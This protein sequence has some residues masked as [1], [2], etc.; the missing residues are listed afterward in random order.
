MLGKLEK[1]ENH[2]PI[3]SF[4]AFS[5][6]LSTSGVFISENRDM[7]NVFYCLNITELAFAFRMAILP[8][9]T[10]LPFVGGTA[11]N[12]LRLSSVC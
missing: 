4:S 5:R 2:S 7:V 11:H 1:V 10:P 12:A 6:V 8:Y 9:P 3:G